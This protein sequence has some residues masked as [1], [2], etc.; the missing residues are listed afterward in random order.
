VLTVA[1][2]VALIIIME[3]RRRRER[4]RCGGDGS[5]NFRPSLNMARGRAERFKKVRETLSDGF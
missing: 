3:R 2:A 1:V 5:V 4:R